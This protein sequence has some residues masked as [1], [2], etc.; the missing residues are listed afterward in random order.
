MPRRHQQAAADAAVCRYCQLP[1]DGELSVL[2]PAMCFYYIAGGCSRCAYMQITAFCLSAAASGMMVW[3]WWRLD[4]ESRS[5]V[6][7]LYGWFASLMCVGSCFGAAAWVAYMQYLAAFYTAGNAV[8]TPVLADRWTMYALAYNMLVKFY[9]LYALEFFCL[10][11]AK[12]VVLDRMKDFV[13][14]LR[15][16]GATRRWTVGG[17]IVMAAVLTG[18]A[19]GLVGNI[20]AAVFFQDAANFY[21]SSAAAYA[22]NK[23][24]AGF[25]SLE[26]AFEKVQLAQDAQGVQEFAEVAVLLLIILAFV[27]VGVA[28]ARRVNSVLNVLVTLRTE[29]NSAAS[30]KLRRQILGTVAVVFVTFLLRAVFSTMHALADALQNAATTCQ[31]TTGPCDTQCFN[32]FAD[33]QIWLFYTP[34]F[35]LSVVL[36]SSPLAMLVALWGMTSDRALQRM[37]LGPQPVSSVRQIMLRGRRGGEGLA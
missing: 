34:E 21:S 8:E 26:L 18:N 7:P 32:V 3:R 2:L 10:S 31:Y 28:S 20:V 30:R 27:V 16:D 22:A 5:L 9:V 6:W 17:R 13:S 1:S 4:E 37:K 11:V 36:I 35:Q 19:V 12:L 23:S 24:H 29:S 15:A 25:H 33:I 14:V